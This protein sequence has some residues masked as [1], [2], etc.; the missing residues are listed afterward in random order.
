MCKIRFNKIFIKLSINKSHFAAR[1]FHDCVQ[2]PY[3][4]GGYDFYRQY[5]KMDV[6]T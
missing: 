4:V 5:Q 3:L 1:R 2:K 6:A